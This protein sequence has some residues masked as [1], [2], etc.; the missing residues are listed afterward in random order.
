MESKILRVI[1]IVPDSVR[2]SN[3]E[4]ELNDSD[5][6]SFNVDPG[7]L[8]NSG[9]EEQEIHSRENN[10]AQE[11][12]VIVISESDSED[13]QPKEKKK[14][15]KVDRNFQ[16][17]R[18]KCKKLI[19]VPRKS[20]TSFDVTPIKKM[21]NCEQCNAKF[22][23]RDMLEIHKSYHDIGSRDDEEENQVWHPV[24]VINE[25]EPTKCDQCNSRFPTVNL[26]DVHK[27]IYHVTNFPEITN[28]GQDHN[29]SMVSID[30]TCE[31][32]N[33]SFDSS[34][35]LEAQT[36]NHIRDGFLQD[37]ISSN[38]VY[39]DNAE[40]QIS[41]ALNQSEAYRTVDSDFSGQTFNDCDGMFT[42]VIIPDNVLLLTDAEYNS[43][44]SDMHGNNQFESQSLANDWDINEQIDH[45]EAMNP[46]NNTYICLECDISCTQSFVLRGHMILK[47]N[48]KD[49]TKSNSHD[50][51]VERELCDMRFRYVFS[52]IAH[53]K[54]THGVVH[55]VP[56]PRK[57]KTQEES[58]KNFCS[59]IPK[60]K[61]K[62][63]IFKKSSYSSI[64]KGKSTPAERWIMN[65]SS[66]EDRNLF[67][68]CEKIFTGQSKLSP[69]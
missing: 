67:S 3:L 66:D 20:A 39:I 40:F 5:D 25:S 35:H 60:E 15:E 12:P 2:Q 6:S 32:C 65:R 33:S 38:E 44:S 29:L 18:S 41:D 45:Q 36:E 27:S 64:P 37:H 16:L 69:R 13:E 62:K 1:N 53:M 48:V 19:S 30:Y 68:R 10:A 59:T 23:D 7:L 58:Q 31:L 24:T 47:H 22:T 4:I 28:T 14:A 61:R 51:T 49:L 21:Y 50:T 9:L 63:I 52:L 46:G 55:G 56:R 43:T 8:S 57:E 26:L 11:I 42:R 34:Q 17:D 54:I